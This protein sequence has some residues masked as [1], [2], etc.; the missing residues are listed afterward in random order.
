M[1]TPRKSLLMVHW[2]DRDR[3]EWEQAIAPGDI[4][5]P[6]GPASNWRPDTH[7]FVVHGYGY[8][9]AWLL[10]TDRLDPASPPGER[11]TRSNL[12]AYVDYLQSGLATATVEN[13]LISLDRALFSIA[14]ETDR[15]LLRQVINRVRDPNAGIAAKRVRLQD[16]YDLFQLGL[17]LMAE[18]G[19]A[20]RKAL[21]PS[22][23]P[24]RYRDGLIIA[25]LAARPLRRKNFANL[26]L[27]EHLRLVDGH[28]WMFI[29]AEETKTHQEIE[30]P[31]PADLVCPFEHYLDVHR[32]ALLQA[33][34]RKEVACS[35]TGPLWIS[36]R[37]GRALSGHTMNLRIGEHT[38]R[39][40]D[41]HLNMHLFRDCAATS[42]AIRD[43]KHVR[44]ATAI[45]GHRC[46]ETTE[47]HYNL[48]RSVEAAERHHACL[49]E[50]LMEE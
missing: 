35:R 11:L 16:S 5:D 37:S 45:L 12:A 25:L 1:N 41:H 34:N 18:A 40:F 23:R 3:L 10:N 49:D 14:P 24:I 47:R 20:D 8:W 30:L 13:H 9:L 42:V 29:P 43:P 4:L 38:G 19:D 31:L 21:R 2:P 33:C 22:M 27:G 17:Q 32:P 44:I 36:A 28:W 15:S 26:I 7:R 39:S 46:F 48:A 50:L 6:G